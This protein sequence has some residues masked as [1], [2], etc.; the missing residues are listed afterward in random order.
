MKTISSLLLCAAVAI[1][2]AGCNSAPAHDHDHDHAHAHG[3]EAEAHPDGAIVLSPEMAQRFGVTTAKAAES[4]IGAVVKVGGT[5]EAA[6]DA[7]G[8]VTATTSG[9]VTLGR[10]INVGSQVGAG[11][12]VASIKADN[13]SGGDANRAAKAALDAAQAEY[14]RVKP[15]WDERLVTQ[16]QYNAAVAELNRARAAFS[17]SAATG[18]AVSPMAGVITSLAVQTGQYVEV[19]A[20]IA[21]VSALKELT[22]TAQLP[23]RHLAILSD[24]ADARIVNP[25]TGQSTTLSALHGRR[26]NSNASA[27]ASGYIPVVFTFANDG[28]WVPGSA[29][30]V[31]LLG[32]GSRRALTVPVGALCEQQ[33]SFFVFTRL[34]EDCYTKVPV[35]VGVNDGTQV[36]ITSGLKGGE[37]VVVSGVTTVR[38]AE[39][40]GAIPEGH[41]HNH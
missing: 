38:L 12:A 13:V 17:A 11:N 37:E 10:G 4:E 35:S 9:I 31:Y 39:S 1:S 33:G 19:G 21:T 26:L 40:A 29:V 18:R 22:L 20:V 41:S 34:D 3:H 24:F 15:L 8:V 30:E 6:S 32:H 28:T 27:G 5:I 16:A 7:Q 36:E 25:Q 23:A 2:L 14:D